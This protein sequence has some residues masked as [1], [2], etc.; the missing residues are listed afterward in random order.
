VPH[1]IQSNPEAHVS[2]RKPAWEDSSIKGFLSFTMAHARF[3]GNG[4]K[5]SQAIDQRLCYEVAES[6]HAG[7]FDCTRVRPAKPW[8]ATFRIRF[9][10]FSVVV[11]FQSEYLS[12]F[13]KCAV[14]T[15]IVPSRW[16]APNPDT[17]LVE[18]NRARKVIKEVIQQNL[19]AES[20]RWMTEN[21]MA[22]EEAA[23]PSVRIV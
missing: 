16:R 13:R 19:G 15:W 8:G 23:A 22:D 2:R 5:R 3:E 7:G 11:M 12:H 14:L 20:L 1:D 4:Q 18:W 17:V 10:R 6:V 21:E 9:E